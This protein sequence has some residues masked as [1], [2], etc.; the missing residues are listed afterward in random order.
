MNVQYTLECVFEYL[1]ID[2]LLTA[3][4]VCQLWRDVV[5]GMVIL[6]ELTCK[7][8]L[9]NKD[10]YDAIRLNSD[11]LLKIHLNSWNLQE[12]LENNV[13]DYVDSLLGE[14]LLFTEKRNVQ[15]CNIICQRFVNLI[16]SNRIIPQEIGERLIARHSND[17]MMYVMIYLTEYNIIPHT[18]QWY[19]F[20]QSQPTTLRDQTKK[21]STF[22]MF[23]G[24][25]VI[26]MRRRVIFQ[27]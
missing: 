26:S 16:G 4:Q 2:D 7:Q 21:A 17:T 10:I 24:W 3:K 13:L 11:K 14:N 22:V 20:Y 25:E 15:I 18:E 8:V 19:E 12:L 23:H 5:H 9:Q 6:P 27:H 1:P